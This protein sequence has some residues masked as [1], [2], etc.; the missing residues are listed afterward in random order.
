MERLSAAYERAR[1]VEFDNESRLLFVCDCHRGDGSLSDEFTRN[2]NTFV[3]ALDFYFTN[4]F[5]YI[6]LGDGDELWEHRSFRHIRRAHADSFAA[7]KRFFDDDRCIMVWGNHND[8]LSRESYVEQN[9]YT[10]FDRHARTQ[11]DF[12]PGIKP[13]EALL[14]RH[15]DTGQ[16]LLALHGH[17]GDFA[18][19]Q[20]SLVAKLALRYFWRHLHALGFRSPASP[21]MND[22]K[23]E[24]SEREYHAWVGAHGTPLICGHTH[25]Y[26]YPF[27]DELPYFNAGACVYPT[28]MTAIE[29]SDGLIQLV[30]WRIISNT[31]GVLQVT[32][33]V[34]AGPDPVERFQMNRAGS[35]PAR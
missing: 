22:R 2:E 30:R 10:L 24:R 3:H 23:R 7:I 4:G 33:E 32:R 27:G 1:V 5:T 14:L 28:S 17:Q 8:E 6:E 31:Q 34:M 35:A 20:A 15:R 11:R 18:N 19:D 21:A 12:L 16:E 13:C 25:L 29:L 26:S 9:L